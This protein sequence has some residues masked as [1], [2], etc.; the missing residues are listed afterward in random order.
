MLFEALA[1]GCLSLN[2]VQGV[3]DISDDRRGV[4]FGG[5]IARDSVDTEF[6]L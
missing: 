2:L 3:F 1:S 4:A 5:S 6:L